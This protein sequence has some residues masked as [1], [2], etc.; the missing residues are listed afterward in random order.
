MPEQRYPQEAAERTRFV[1]ER[2]GGRPAHDPWRYQGLLVE[3]EPGAD[4][5]VTR[6]GTIFLTGRECPWRCVMCDLWQYTTTAD[7]PAGAIPAQIRSARLAFADERVTCVKLYNAGSFFDPRAVPERDHEHIAAA[8]AGLDRVIVECH[9]SLIGP[10][11][12]KFLDALGAKRTSDAPGPALEI[13]MGLETAHPFALEALNKRMTVDGFAAA[14]ARVC[15]LGAGLRVFLLISPPFVA[16][17]D[18]DTWLLQSI[19]LAFGCGATCVSLVPTRSGNGAMEALASAGEFRPPRLAD[20]ERSVGRAHAEHA[21]RGRILIDVWDLDRFATCGA[22][23]PARRAR[24]QAINLSQQLRP[25]VTCESCG[26][27][28]WPAA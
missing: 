27:P 24:L 19:D 5:E 8:L 22:C 6:V 13:A 10:A 11:V 3:D 7:T 28:E 23:L 2:R 4:G 20:I 25:G 14:A 9:P 17:G 18:Q 1:L 26:C 15:R 16:P 21:G 12:G